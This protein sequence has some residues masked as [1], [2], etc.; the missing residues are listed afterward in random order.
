MVKEA[1]GQVQV[2]EYFLLT[3]V[4]VNIFQMIHFNGKSYGK[5]RKVKKD[6]VCYKL[7]TPPLYPLMAIS[8]G[9]GLICVGYIVYVNEASFNSNSGLFLFF[10]SVFFFGP[11]LATLHQIITK[12][13]YY[14]KVNS[15][16]FIYY[17]GGVDVKILF[18]D[19][20]L[21]DYI[22]KMM[23]LKS[24]TKYRKIGIVFKLLDGKE[25]ELNTWRYGFGENDVTNLLRD[26]RTKST[27]PTLSE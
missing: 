11:T 22:V 4:I 9:L 19:V 2:N 3:L 7:F 25:I 1:A 17:R 10:I 15:E 6:E 16:A 13:N 27:G 5:L 23:S 8:A 14:F 20:E 26:I 18:K 21:V 24:G 12:P